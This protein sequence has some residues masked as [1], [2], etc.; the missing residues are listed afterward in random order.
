[1]RRS[2]YVRKLAG[3]A[4]ERRVR[5]EAAQTVQGRFATRV[6]DAF[7]VPLSLAWTP[8]DSPLVYIKRAKV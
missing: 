1:M 4:Q 3:R 7:S 5:A 2:Q 6:A 8:E